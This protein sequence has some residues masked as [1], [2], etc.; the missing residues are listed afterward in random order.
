M[1]TAAWPLDRDV[2]FGGLRH[3]GWTAKD[4][5]PS[6]GVIALAQTTDGYLWIAT[7][8][9]GGLYRFD[10]RL[11][12]H[13]EMPRSKQLSSAVIY[14]LFAPKSGG[15]WIGF[16][17]GGAAFFQGGRLTVY[18]EKEGFPAGTV[19]DFA[20]DADGLLWAITTR[21]LARFKHDG[22]Q[23]FPTNGATLAHPSGLVIDTEGTLW[24]PYPGHVLFLPRGSS[25]LHELPVHVNFPAIAES[26]S[27]I[28]WVG[29]RTGIRAVRKIDNPGG[30]P[31][32][33]QSGLL[34]D[35][36]GGIWGLED[37]HGLHRAARVPA[38]Q[39]GQLI[40]WP[41]IYTARD[42]LT[43]NFGKS[44][45]LEDREGNVWMGSLRGLDRFSNRA[46]NRAFDV[47]MWGIGLVAADGGNLWAAASAAVTPRVW[48]FNDGQ[49]V[50]QPAPL[51]GAVSS[52]LRT[53]DGSVLFAG[54][55]GIWRYRNSWSHLAQL[56]E[57][58]AGWEVQGM[59]EDPSGA[60]W[61][62]IVHNGLFRFEHG[63]WTNT[64]GLPSLPNSP[65]VTVT[66]DAAG[67][68]W[69][70]Y[71]G[72]RI[73]RVDGD[74]VTV[75]KG[76]DGLDV[77]NVTAI[78]GGRTRI[79]AGGEF[80]LSVLEGEGFRP[81]TATASSQLAGITG[82]VETPE[83]D[84]WVHGS[85]GLVHFSAADLHQ[86]LERRSGNVNGETFDAPYG[87]EGAGLP[88]RPHP[89]LIEGTNGTLWLAT[90]QAVFSLDPKHLLRNALPPQV[91]IT[92]VRV[93]SEPLVPRDGLQL[94]A[95]TTAL[96]IAFVGLSLTMPEKV[97]YRY[98]LDGLTT[99]WQEADGNRE[100]YF[101]NMQ[102]GTYRFHVIA[103]NS[104]GVWSD[105]GAMFQFR[106]PPA[107]TQT[108][109]FDLLCALG[110]IVAL[111]LVVRLRVHQASARLRL[112]L[113]ERLRERE[114]IA[115]ELHDTLLQSTQG[116]MLR[117][118]AA[119]NRLSPGDPTREMLNNAL[120]RADE[121]L[122]EARDRVQ[123]LR[124]PLE[125]HAD[126]AK[127]LAEVGREL[128]LGRT[129]EYGVT[130]EGTP[131]KLPPKIADEVYRIGREALLN[132]FHHSQAVSIDLTIAY[133]PADILV[134]VRDS[135]RGIDPDVLRE[136]ARAGHWGLRGMRERAQE[137][138][139]KIRISSHP[140]EGTEVQLTVP[141]PSRGLRRL[142]GQWLSSR[143]QL[144]EGSQ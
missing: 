27:G 132:A 89:T 138:H 64:A 137:I 94:P 136:G 52:L 127:S 38:V 33:Q 25:T 59:A 43:S 139:A 41:E 37:E 82:I 11:F 50:P 8:Q 36:D 69:L 135:G 68:I 116:L 17:F 74:T 26:P 101:T 113:G 40:R 80:G 32:S 3:T 62:S 79:W 100:A 131:R 134:R 110:V 83:G 88:L 53:S 128:A 142:W 118:E 75:F 65:P 78:Y 55:K 57:A 67:R 103:A 31:V 119:N 15:L 115:R 21:G 92:S 144:P 114:R 96:H 117:V 14:K 22:W 34:V 7:Q 130:V 106:I 47:P 90:D 99:D 63:T 16:T 39:V 1:S 91:A 18:T 125:A 56:P 48:R 73:A 20:E 124:I 123:N 76:D 45:I 97:K 111:A 86:F 24:L 60:L 23:E 30:Q 84:L 4:G 51:S 9:S 85:A 44:A 126:L 10:G 87:L 129:V 70:G 12:E 71:T 66:A 54:A 42:G 19:A 122:A 46:L 109:W 29:D 77:G 95:R 72:S 120:T 93:G 105:P 141:S 104:D 81:I 143:P 35:R 49:L 6:G 112:R 98:K 107:F 2:P 121:V 102:P 61:V 108:V 13:V 58:A 140:D 5:A 133:R 28:V